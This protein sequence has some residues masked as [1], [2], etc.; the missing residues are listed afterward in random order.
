MRYGFNLPPLQLELGAEKNQSLLPDTEGFTP[1]IIGPLQPAEV[2]P[3]E[4]ARDYSRV[5]LASTQ[6][7]GEN[8]M[9]G[10]YLPILN[11][12]FQLLLRCFQVNNSAP[13]ADPSHFYY[14]ERFAA[15][16]GGGLQVRYFETGGKL[17]HEELDPNF[18]RGNAHNRPALF[19]FPA[20]ER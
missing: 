15:S 6:C 10:G 1:P 2:S 9:E 4:E 13:P 16:Y 18:W 11:P 5:Y 14:P 12:R 19:P 3:A 20:V 7:Y 8:I 17:D